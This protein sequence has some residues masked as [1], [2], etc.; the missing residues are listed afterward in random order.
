MLTEKTE[1]VLRPT[2]VNV[3]H[4]ET[5]AA[6]NCSATGD[7]STPVSLTWYH[8]DI[9]GYESEVHNIAN[10][11]VVADNGTLLLFVPENASD[12]WLTL[13]GT[14]RCHATNGYSFDD[15]AAL[16]VP[17]G[18]IIT[19]APRKLSVSQLLDVRCVVDIDIFICSLFI[20]ILASENQF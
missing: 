14:Y 13:G 8:T 11:I 3:E 7:D 18:V 5:F 6:F 10:R 12:V 19:P 16:L 17:S 9:H 1:I 15:A 4:F 2:D 20:Y